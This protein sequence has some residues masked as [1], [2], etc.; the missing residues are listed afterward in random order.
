[1]PSITVHYVQCQV[2]CVVLLGNYLFLVV[3]FV[4]VQYQLF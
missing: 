1:M 3:P 2:V 4:M